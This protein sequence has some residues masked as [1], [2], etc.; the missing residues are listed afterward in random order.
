MILF[1][2]NTVCSISERVRGVCVDALYK[3]TFTLLYGPA[4]KI[5]NFLLQWKGEVK[6]FLQ[7][8]YYF[9]ASVELRIFSAV[10]LSRCFLLV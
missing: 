4:A 6:L 1:A 5:G 9:W 2:G 10:S 7:K 8:M 3:S